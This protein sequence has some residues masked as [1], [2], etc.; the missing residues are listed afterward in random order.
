M[1]RVFEY[2]SQEDVLAE[3]YFDDIRFDTVKLVFLIAPTDDELAHVSQKLNIQEIIIRESIAEDLRPAIIERAHFTQIILKAPALV[4]SQVVP[5]SFSVFASERLLLIASREELDALKIFEEAETD[6]KRAYF[7]KGST[8]LL[9]R[10]CEEIM[11][12][13]FKYL[14]T[15]EDHISIIENHMLDTSRK[16]SLA[17]VFRIKTTLI[18]FAKSITAIRD[19]IMGIEKGMAKNLKRED[20]GDF[21]LVYHDII[22]LMDLVGTYR[23]VLSESIEIY[24]TSVSNN[25][26]I[27]I[28]R[29][30]AWGSLVLIPTFIASLYGMNFAH[31]PE[32]KWQYG[33]IFSLGLMAVSVFFFYRMFKHKGYL[34]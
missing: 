2:I 29:M 15:I 25:L 7:Q 1:L 26:N 30:T 31:M 6:M 27:S 8:Y 4:K 23:E 17:E 34:E 19:V 18:Y 16:K 21:I 11:D 14:D 12:G 28:K 9:Y 32:I 22:Q 10:L 3:P 13:Y 20:T 24:L 33:Y 5:K